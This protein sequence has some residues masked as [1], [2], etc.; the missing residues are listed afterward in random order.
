M[1]LGAVQAE[2]AAGYPGTAKTNTKAAQK[3]ADG[4]FAEKLRE[5]GQAADGRNQAKQQE[6]QPGARAVAGKADANQTAASGTGAGQAASAN[7]DT[8]NDKGGSMDYSEFFQ[9]KIN[10][11]FVKVLN[12]DTEPS[13]QIGSRSFTE[14]DWK[15]FLKKF[16]SVQDALRKLMREEHAKRAAKELNTRQ[17]FVAR[18]KKTSV[19][20]QSSLLFTDSTSCVYPSADETKEEIRYVTWYTKEGIFCRKMGQTEDEW[21]LTFED[22]QQYDKVMELIGQFPSDWN[23]RFAAHENFWTDFL[24]GDID[25]ER[26]VDFMKGTDKGVPDYFITGDGASY[27]D[28]DR[29]QWAKYL[30]AFGNEFYTASEFQKKWEMGIAAHAANKTKISNPYDR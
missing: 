10:E 30:N 17:A 4:S 13:Y 29:M 7:T 5:G 18:Q 6:N 1:A 15:K 27:A 19:A 11:I 23:L 8:E 3:Y 21:S 9:E 20:D 2:A 12:G 24:N 28:R 16:D 22:P 25:T 14:K 26:F